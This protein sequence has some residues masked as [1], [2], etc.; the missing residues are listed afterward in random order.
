M[1][2]ALAATDVIDQTVSNSAIRH[3]ALREIDM[4]PIDGN[5]LPSY[6]GGMEDVMM[7]TT[8]IKIDARLYED[9]DDCLT[10]AAA[11]VAAERGL[12]GWDLSPRW[13]DDQHDMILLDVPMSERD[14]ADAADL[15]LCESPDGW[16][17]HAPGSTDEQIASGAAPAL[18]DG[19]W[20]DETRETGRPTAAD[21]QEALYELRRLAYLHSRSE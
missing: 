15:V 20:T 11:D 12:Q 18:A 4:H 21:Y 1:R 14:M 17:L 7:S 13:E 3:S 19:P 6:I 2:P 9:Y 5:R 8:T 16:S 10:A